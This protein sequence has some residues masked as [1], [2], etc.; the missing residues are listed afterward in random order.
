MRVG[1]WNVGS[2]SGK[3]GEYCEE[4]RKKMIGVLLTGGEMERT[5]YY[6]AGDEGKETLAVMVWKRRWSWWC[7]SY[8]Q[9][10]AV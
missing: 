8:G 2:L 9:G 3:G 10:G 5:G 7:G 6:D 4:L 1:T